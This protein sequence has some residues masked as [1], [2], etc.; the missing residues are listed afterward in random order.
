MSLCLSVG[1]ASKPS[2]WV[3]K[4]LVV[5]GERIKALDY[6]L[7]LMQPKVTLPIR[8]VSSKKMHVSLYSK[9]DCQA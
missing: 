6:T 3:V 2:K 9:S 4:V 8:S 5:P 1:T 7:V